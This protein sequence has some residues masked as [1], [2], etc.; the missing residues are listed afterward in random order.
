MPNIAVDDNTHKE[1]KKLSKTL[2]IS[3]GELVQHSVVYFKKTGINPA[4]ADNESPIKAIKE[5]D[6]HIGQIVAFIR[7]QEKEKLNPLLEHLIIISKQLDDTITK[8]PKSERFEDVFKAVNQ[9][10]SLLIDSHK[11]Q[12]GAVQKTQQEINQGNQTE[13]ENVTKKLNS[14][15]QGF[16]TLHT[17]QEAI[18]TAIETK[19]GKKMFG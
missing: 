19:L 12:V 18:K 2:D 14:L 11:K 15:I 3:L 8:L 7:T 6:K 5:L 17:G 13:L 9:H 10:A 4:N 1:A 16:N